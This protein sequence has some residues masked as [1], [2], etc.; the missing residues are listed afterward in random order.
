MLTL[1]LALTQGLGWETVT[2]ARPELPPDIVSWSFTTCRRVNSGLSGC[3]K[4]A[5][6]SGTLKRQ[7]KANSRGTG[8][9]HWG[10]QPGAL[11]VNPWTPRL[12]TVA[13]IQR[14]GEAGSGESFRLTLMLAPF[15]PEISKKKK[16]KK[17]AEGVKDNRARLELTCAVFAQGF[18]RRK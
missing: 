17:H 12:T 11:S 7:K 8:W 9:F 5:D 4:S 1:T 16:K 6:K 10:G 15:S 2:F 18:R 3:I 14:N 13:Q